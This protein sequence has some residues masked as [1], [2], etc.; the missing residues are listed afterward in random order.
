VGAFVYADETWFLRSAADGYGWSPRRKPQRIPAFGPT[1]AR[2]LYGSVDV[3][4]QLMH[5]C[6]TPK[7]N[8][9]QTVRYLQSL[10]RHYQRRNKRYVVI[11]WDNASWH[12]SAAVREWVQAHNQRSQTSPHALRLY[13]IPLPTYSPW[14]NPMEPIIKHAKE[15]VGFACEHPSLDHRQQA[16]H[17]YLTARNRKRR[18]A[19]SLT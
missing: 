13:C 15:S 3:D 19:Q 6:F 8:S 5:W 16:W 1:E 4:N 17:R 12:Q 11:A 18:Q 7:T 9:D 14:L 10:A 2:V